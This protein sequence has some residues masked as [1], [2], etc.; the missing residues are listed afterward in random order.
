MQE[1]KAVNIVYVYSRK[2]H[3]TLKAKKETLLLA[4]FIIAKFV[5]SYTLVHPVYELQRDEYLHLDLGRH[6]AWGYTSVPPFTG[7]VSYLILQLGNSIF[8]VKFF[9]ALFGALTTWAVWRLVKDLK[10]GLFALLLSATAVTFSVV[11]RI[12]ILYQPNSY[13]ILSW[14]LVYL[15]L[16]RYLDTKDKLWIWS[17]G[18][19]FAIGFLNKYNILFLGAS[20]LPALLLTEN[21]R[22][23]LKK[24][25]YIA[26]ILAFILILPNLMWQQQ[27]QFPVIH[28][29]KELAETQ[30]VNVKRLDFIK[31]QFLFF[32]GSVFVLFAA[33]T[34]FFK[35]PPFSKYRFVLY[36]YILTILLFVF[37]KAKT[38]YAIGLYPV[39]LAFGS[40]Y[41]EKILNK[42]WRFH[43]RKVA[44]LIPIFLFVPIIKRAFPVYPPQKLESMAASS[45]NMHT[46]EDGKQHPLDQDFADMLGW[47]ELAHKVDLAYSKVKDKKHM[48]ILCDNYGEAGAIN[49]YTKIPGLRATSFNADYLNW[50][51][52][53]HTITTIISVKEVEEP[54]ELLVNEKRLF[55]NIKLTGSI[56]N[57]FAREFGTR[58]YVLSMPKLDVSAALRKYKLRLLKTYSF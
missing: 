1:V 8:W 5:L 29:M 7:L 45:G 12:N 51:K 40:V 53:D 52:L 56:E 48:L 3:N 58:I 32:I 16:L 39:L 54:S 33:F 21:R 42:G 19:V 34:S 41:L 26:V 13:D 55:K 22:I 23:F 30:L 50:I 31:E 17:T 46:W 28:H 36:S 20:L 15:C 37:L 6:L 18:I 43:L 44:I 25:V 27:N 49:Y 24:D 47:E 11:T 14:T 57:R 10:G 4:F 9:P 38:Y 2:T 35:Y